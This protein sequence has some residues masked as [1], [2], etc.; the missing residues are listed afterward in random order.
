[1]V[2]PMLPALGLDS[3][4]GRALAAAAVGAGSMAVVHLNDP[5]FWIAADMA[6]LSPGRGLWLITVGSA[7]TS[8]ALLVG[9]LALRLVL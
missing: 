5:V 9:L 4:T 2:E 7:A 8:L 6:K 3:A 1:M